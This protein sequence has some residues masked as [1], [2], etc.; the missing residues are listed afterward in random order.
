M[1]RNYPHKLP[2]LH[3]THYPHKLNA[4]APPPPPPPHPTLTHKSI[5]PR[6]HLRKLTAPAQPPHPTLNARERIN[7]PRVRLFTLPPSSGIEVSEHEEQ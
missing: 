4:P 6:N 2:A 5:G 7:C 1:V 3:G